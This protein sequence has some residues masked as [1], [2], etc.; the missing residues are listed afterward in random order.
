MAI[1]TYTIDKMKGE[2]IE[3]GGD[4]GQ[5]NKAK[6]KEN[7][8]DAFM[9]EW[10]RVKVLPE[11]EAGGN[12]DPLPKKEAAKAVPK[13]KVASK[14]AALPDSTEPGVGLK[15]DILPGEVD[16]TPA[17]LSKILLLQDEWLQ[18]VL[19]G[20]KVLELRKARL[21]CKG[22]E[23]MY[24]AVGSTIYGRCSITPLVTFTD[25]V[26]F[27]KLKDKHCWDQD[28]PPYA[29]PFIGHVLSQVQRVKPLDFLKLKG[30]QGRCLFR[31]VGWKSED[32]ELASQQEI[33]PSGPASKPDEGLE[34][35]K[36]EKKKPKGKGQKKNKCDTEEPKE[37]KTKKPKSTDIKLLPA[38]ALEKA[39]V[40]QI[41]HKSHLL[42]STDRLKA[43][44]EVLKKKTAHIDVHISGG[45]LAHVNNVAFK[46]APSLTGAYLAGTTNGKFVEVK[47]VWVPSWE[48]HGSMELWDLA[49]NSELEEWLSGIEMEVVGVLLVVPELETPEVSQLQVFDKLWAKDDPS[50]LFGLTGSTKRSTLYRLEDGSPKE[51]NL[52]VHWTGKQSHYI[53]HIVSQTVAVLDGIK[54]HAKAS[55]VLGGKRKG[56]PN[57]SAMKEFWN[58]KRRAIRQQDERSSST[59]AFSQNM[60]NI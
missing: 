36:S 1:Q 17:L 26:Q 54:E 20:T 3:A 10:F 59:G 52:Q 45:A 21:T 19:D 44:R 50:F 11:L 49:C 27:A 30:C 6:G 57:K 46:R 29:F 18:K 48:C 16:E 31:P 23:T 24:L 39:E 40:V 60:R 4:A 22:S 35:A 32:E 33:E 47:A 9:R 15:A 13:A 42:P 7:K 12:L 56:L 43:K 51:L 37:P 41:D 8:K 5:F 38:S 28:D 25:T 58:A 53:A 2:L 34:E 14:S 55:V